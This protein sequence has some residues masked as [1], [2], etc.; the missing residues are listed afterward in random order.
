MLLQLLWSRVLQLRWL[1]QLLRKLLSEPLLDLLLLQPLLQ[2]ELG[3]AR[4]TL[5][6]RGVAGIYSEYGEK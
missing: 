4:L 2:A 6:T 1:W 5:W 3:Q